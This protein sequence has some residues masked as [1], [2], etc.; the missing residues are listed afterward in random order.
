KALSKTSIVNRW[1]R[2][3]PIIIVACGDPTLSGANNNIDYFAVDVAIAMEHIILAATDIDLGSCW[4]AA[5]NEKKVKEILE[6]P[7]RIRVV[8]LTPLGYPAQKSGM[9][10][11]IFKFFARSKNRKNLSEIVRYEKW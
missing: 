11:K 7:N 1:L 5:F 3:V 10:D 4:I 6:I 2:K 9:I 8:A